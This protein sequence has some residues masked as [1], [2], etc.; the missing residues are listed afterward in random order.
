[1]REKFPPGRVWLL[2]ILF[3]L[4]SCGHSDIDPSVP[5]P[6][7]QTACAPANDPKKPE[8]CITKPGNVITADPEPVR[9]WRRSNGRSVK[10]TWTAAQ[11]T[12]LQITFPRGQEGCVKNLRCSGNQCTAKTDVG[13]V[14][15]YECTYVIEYDGSTIDP[16]VIIDD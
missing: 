12:T 10:I 14:G 15:H 3:I 5:M 13:T 2:P 4:P 11:A 16:L 6:K 9:A 8:V 7:A 1:M